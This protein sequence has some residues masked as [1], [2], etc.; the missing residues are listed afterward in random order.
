MFVLGT[1]ETFA[2]TT[3]S[4]LLPM[5]VAQR[6]PRPRQRAVD[7]RADHR[8]SARRAA[9]RGGTVRRRSRPGRSSRRRS[10][11]RPAPCW[12]RGSPSRSSSTRAHPATNRDARSSKGCAGC[13]RTPPCARLTITIVAFNVTF[14]AA[15]SVLVL[16]AV[17]TARPRR[18][19]FRPDHVGQRGRRRAR[20]VVVRMDRATGQPR[21]HHAG[22]ADHRDADPSDPGADD[23][24]GRGDAGVL[25]V[26]CP[27]RRVGHDGDEH[28]PPRRADELP[29]PCRPAST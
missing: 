22:R 24:A 9:D 12:C 8:Q 1:A 2:D 13:G 25:R 14:G 11:W 23:I 7:G 17:R 18:R 3:T 5:M 6:R 16:Y 20:I 29:G 10:A 26:R 4:T 21:R 27:R 19:R 28:P 15:W